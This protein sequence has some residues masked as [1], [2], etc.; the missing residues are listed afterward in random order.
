M[1]KFLWYDLKKLR[2]DSKYFSVSYISL[3]LIQ[4]PLYHS[5][6]KN[7]NLVTDLFFGIITSIFFIYLTF[8][9]KNFKMSEV[10]KNI[11]S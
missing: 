1:K 8:M 6:F 11:F 7:K 9:K 10:Y 2:E 4:L 3:I 5:F